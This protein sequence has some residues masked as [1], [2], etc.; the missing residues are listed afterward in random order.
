MNG[1]IRNFKLAALLG[2]ITMAFA[3]FGV[4]NVATTGGFV[5]GNSIVAAAAQNVATVN[6]TDYATLQEAID[7]AQDG[8]TIVLVA[9]VTEDVLITQKADVDLVID[10]N[11][12]SFTGVMTVFGDARHAGAE[13][14][15]I[16]NINFYA[17]ADKDSCIVSP[18]RTVYN[19]YSYSHNVTVDSCNFY[20]NVATPHEAA[21]V[22]HEDGGDKNWT[23]IN[24]TVDENMHS[25]LQVQ[26]VNGKLVVDGCTVNS[27]NG[28]NLNSCTNVEI[29]NCDMNVNGYAVRAGVKTG[30]DLAATKTFVLENNVLKSECND[31][32]AVVMFRASSTNTILDMSKNVVS[33]TTHI[34]SATA[35][36]EVAVNGNYWD[37]EEAP[38]VVVGGN[39]VEV[40]VDSY[41]ADETLGT[42][43]PNPRGSVTPA[44]TR[45]DGFWGEGKSNANESYVVEIYEN[46]VKIVS[47]SLN[48]IGNIMD[49]TYKNVTWSVPFAGSTDQ[50]WT[51]QWAT[52]YPRA[53]MYPDTVKLVVDGE[54]VS[55]NSVQYNAPDNLNEIEAFVEDNAG[56][57]VAYTKLADAFAA[58]VNGNEVAIVRAG[59]YALSTAGK[60]ITITGAVDGVVFD[61]IGKKNMS[62]ANVTFNNITFDYYPN[63]NY[64][65]LQHSGNL[66]YNDCTFNGQVFLY[67][68][69]ETFNDCTFNQ[70][71]AGSYNV[72]TYAADVVEFNG[73][74]FNCVG[75]SVL[76]YTEDKNAFTELEIK[77]TTFNASAPVDGKAAIEIDTSLT[78]GANITIDKT[79]TANGFA[80]GSESNNTLWNNKKGSDEGNKDIT[81]VVG[82][83]TVLA[84]TAKIG[85]VGY[86]TL[87]EAFA[88]AQ[89]GDTIE[90]VSDITI[91]DDWDCRNNG[92]K[93][94]VPLTI[95]GN[96]HT[97]KLTGK[98]DDKNWN[99]VFRF[100]A[101]AT[102]KNLTIDVSEAKG[103]QRGISAKYSVTVENCKFIGNVSAKRA[104]IFG[105]GAKNEI[106]NVTATITGCEFKGWS[107]GVSDNQ[108]GKDAKA[109]TVTGST[110]KNASV[111]I[112]A[113]ENVTF[114][115]NEL[116]NGYVNISSYTAA[117]TVKVVATGN[118]LDS[119]YAPYNKINTKFEN[120]TADEDFVTLSVSVNGICYTTL[121]E[122]INKANGAEITL[123]GNTKGAGVVID[124]IV[125]INFNGFTYT[126]TSGVEVDEVSYGF[127][128]KP[129]TATSGDTIE[130]TNGAIAVAANADI[131]IVVL[132]AAPVEAS[133]LITDVS[134]AAENATA[135]LANSSM[136]EMRGACNISSKGTAI[137]VNNANE[138]NRVQFIVTKFGD[139]VP[140]VSGNFEVKGKNIVAQIIDGVFY[141]KV[142]SNNADNLWISG[143]KYKKDGIADYLV[144]GKA[145]VKQGKYFVV[146]NAQPDNDDEGDFG[147]GFGDLAGIIGGLIGA[148]DIIGSQ[149][150][151]GSQVESDGIGAAGVVAIVA[152]SL[153]VV[154]AAGV[155]VLWILEK[156]EIFKVSEF[157]EKL[158]E[159]LKKNLKK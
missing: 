55:T 47:A 81:I 67:G 106:G 63:V 98:I 147:Y 88:A 155:C 90:I 62:G 24:C 139:N 101:D 53:N 122:A 73:C 82:D 8:D 115:N 74:A 77:E 19:R 79:T 87:A 156:K 158:E 59:T 17:V 141:G 119:D 131:D 21:A 135:I 124:K 26:N 104:I 56:G 6:G 71:D 152:G 32:D 137:L 36:I 33:G 76:V 35:D 133:V 91:S 80:A 39:E 102:V 58:M 146:V 7:A 123:L 157:L 129:A 5:A 48:D 69:S 134:I 31:G 22:R 130:L 108:S 30:G 150:N 154:I 15:T 34:N 128:I 149:G 116:D 109:V 100:E 64:T 68:I 94:T 9:D 20:G 60:D 57:V 27:K 138:D 125:N 159:K 38:V 126:V 40:E 83:E 140:E 127:Y 145:I 142:R 84:P 136:T 42:L 144:E 96:G 153:A 4:A 61:N 112:S 151:A 2:A 37:G 78:K 132:S 114:T 52:N 120:I 28:L 43:V 92:A 99:T 113:A 103:V 41:Y 105:E 50:Y 143:G 10:G 46:G 75:K 72:W 111:L 118:T 44:Y 18:D 65:G 86:S 11:D 49:G 95:N 89:A 93:F 148:G 3:G 54:V 85:K 14:L 13:T 121:Q 117:D 1:K 97:L 70:N 29:T 110:F 16:K 23:I 45:A 51:V 66:V 12:K 107:Y 25:M